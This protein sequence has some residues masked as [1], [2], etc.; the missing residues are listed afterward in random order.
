MVTHYFPGTDISAAEIE[1][2]YS[3][4]F[5][6]STE[7]LGYYVSPSWPPDVE[8][9]YDPNRFAA[10]RNGN[11]T[12]MFHIAGMGRTL[13]LS[14]QGDMIGA[15]MT[16]WCPGHPEE[17][18]VD[19]NNFHYSW[20]AYKGSLN[21]YPLSSG[22]PD[23]VPVPGGIRH[24]FAEG[25]DY[26]LEVGSASYDDGN[27]PGGVTVT[28]APGYTQQIHLEVNYQKLDVL[29]DLRDDAYKVTTW[30]DGTAYVSIP[31]MQ[32]GL[33][34]AFNSTD[35]PV[36]DQLFYTAWWRYQPSSTGEVIVNWSIIPAGS[37][38]YRL[39][40]FRLNGDGSLTRVSQQNTQGATTV[41]VTGGEL[42]YFQIG[43]SDNTNGRQTFGQKYM[44]NVSGPTSVD[45]VSDGSRLSAQPGDTAPRPADGGGG[46]DGGG[47]DP[48]GG[49]TDPFD[50]GPTVYPPQNPEYVR[51]LGREPIDDISLGRGTGIS[52]LGRR[53]PGAL[54]L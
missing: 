46:G 30:S 38:D 3:I 47:G 48:G 22:D 15:V 33:T 11:Q 24:F 34:Q 2:G 10:Q 43:V 29:N 1:A 44:L 53:Y 14:V 32:A 19:Q 5:V 8:E 12:A 49:G 36:S 40:M 50:P 45:N 25:K 16:L 7:N 41:A 37:P 23:Y 35:D 27:R 42:Y 6:N 52:N 9:G 39:N 20:V 26:Y 17:N 28:P 54:T 13:E 21:T 18:L 31:V 4:D 51:G